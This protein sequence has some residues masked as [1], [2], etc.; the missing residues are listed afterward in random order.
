MGPDNMAQTLHE[1]PLGRPAAPRDER[2]EMTEQ[3]H[4]RGRNEQALVEWRIARRV[5]LTC[6]VF[7]PMAAAINAS[8]IIAEARRNSDTIDTRLPWLLEFTSVI[9]FAPPILLLVLAQRRRLLLSGNALS[10]ALLLLA[11][12]LVFSLMHVAGMAVL[13][14]LPA[15]LIT[16]K[17][18]VLLAEPVHDFIYEYQKDLFPFAVVLSLLVTSRQLEES[19]LEVQLARA[20]AR[21]SGQLTLKCGGRTIH[22]VGSSVGWARAAG[23]YVELRA[24]GRDYLVR[25][26]LTALEALLNDAGVDVARIHRSHI[27][28]RALVR[29]TTPTSDGDFNVR[30]SDG[31]QIRGSRRYRKNLAG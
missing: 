2:P 20:E 1:T 29:E 14:D 15:A 8:S 26:T 22:L 16:G 23:N 6:A 17:D 27:V 19:R 28:N 21:E 12:S 4:M 31:S 25:I 18:Y 7:F 30:L 24:D 13:R 9:A 11:A 5:G 3:Q 10:T